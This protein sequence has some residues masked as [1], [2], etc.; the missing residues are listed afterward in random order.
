[1]TQASMLM[2]RAHVPII[3]LPM[4]LM[5]STAP[6]SI[7]GAAVIA[8]A[9]LL[10]GV[11]LFQLTEPGCPLVAAPEPAVADMRTGLYMCGA[12]ESTLAGLITDE[13][14]IKQY[15]LPCQGLGFGGDNKA[16][17]LQEGVE[18]MNSALGAALIGVDTMDCIGTMDG[19][20]M[21]S[22]AKVVLDN[23]TAGMVRT[24]ISD[25]PM[26]ASDALVEDIR[27]VGPRG[28]FLAQRSTRERAKG[29]G[30]WKPSVYWRETFEA[31]QG[32][33]LVQDAL[34]R[35][36]EL[37]ATHEVKPMPEDV[38]AHIDEVIATQR[39]L[40]GAPV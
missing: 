14:V 19:A 4:P 35:A 40:L 18:G 11:V 39:K 5:G 22:L 21:T 28:H 29:G 36:R 8:L 30:L 16:P 15:G 12:P 7:A 33:T 25:I 23:D 17:D 31:H 26:D 27:A 13:M 24:M 9:E 37:L 6:M 3:V 20:Q 32:R 34:E 38:D 2:A 10:S 1:M